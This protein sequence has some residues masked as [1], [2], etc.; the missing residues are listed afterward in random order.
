MENTEN[1]TSETFAIFLLNYKE[2]AGAFDELFSLQVPHNILRSIIDLDKD[3]LLQCAV[4]LCPSEILEYIIQT[5]SRNMQS[6]L[7]LA[8]S[9]SSLRVLKYIL[10]LLRQV[11]DNCRGLL[12][13]QTIWGETVLHLA[14]GMGNNEIVQLLLDVKNSEGAMIVVQSTKDKW[15]RTAA[16]IAIETGHRHLFLQTQL[17]ESFITI[18]QMEVYSNET[19]DRCLP[20]Q[21]ISHEFMKVLE[22]K[23]K[24]RRND[25]VEEYPVVV[26]KNIFSEYVEKVSATSSKRTQTPISKMMEYPGNPDLLATLLSDLDNYDINGKDMFGLAA[27]HKAASWNKEDLLELILSHSST[28]VNIQAGGQEYKGFTALHFCIENNSRN[29]FEKLMKDKRVDQNIIDSRG[30]TVRALAEKVNCKFFE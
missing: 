2:H 4:E 19:A 25:S 14:A 28:N 16:D 24:N 29:A 20:R 6:V 8:V 23:K 21:V 1:F 17:S 3:N 18:L 15:G 27:I 22:E 5:R 30:R 10:T 11:G 26:V 7:H 13:D 9:S 12:N